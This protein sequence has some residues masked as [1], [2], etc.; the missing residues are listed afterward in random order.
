MI[1]LAL[2][3][4]LGRRAVRVCSC[5][6]NVSQGESQSEVLD[7]VAIT[8]GWCWGGQRQGRVFV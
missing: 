6:G 5:A 8:R 1:F 3:A 7:G 2:E 4:G